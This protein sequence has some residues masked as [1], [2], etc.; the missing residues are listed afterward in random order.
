MTCRD[1]DFNYQ[2][3]KIKADKPSVKKK[4]NNGYRE[5]LNDIK[6]DWG[7]TTSI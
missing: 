1:L 7:N 5:I 2:S 4:W 3:Y 6:K